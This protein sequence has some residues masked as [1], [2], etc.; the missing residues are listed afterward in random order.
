MW[1]PTTDSFIKV[2]YNAN[3]LEGKAENKDA[4]RR[5]LGLS[6]IVRKPLVITFY[7]TISYVSG[8]F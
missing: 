6:S 8:A 3:D 4:I 7:E 1:N 2:Q 5:H